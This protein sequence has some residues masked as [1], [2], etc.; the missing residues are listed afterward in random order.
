MEAG[1]GR[2]KGVLMPR[3]PGDLKLFSK[4]LAGQFW[5]A[6]LRTAAL[7]EHGFWTVARGPLNELCRRDAKI[8]RAGF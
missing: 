7:L 2:V 5:A 4:T 3:Q 6:F 1:K 8:R